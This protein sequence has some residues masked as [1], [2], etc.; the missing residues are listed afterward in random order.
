MSCGR[1]SL[2]AA[3]Y[4]EMSAGSVDFG[5]FD[6]SEHHAIEKGVCNEYEIL[7]PIL[8]FQ[9]CCEDEAEPKREGL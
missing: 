7:H 9:I 8:N 4:E 6:I 5:F 1:W 2:E 3:F